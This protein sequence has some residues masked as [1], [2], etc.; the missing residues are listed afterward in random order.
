MANRDNNIITGLDIGSSSVRIAVGKI[1]DEKYSDKVLQILSLSQVASEGVSRGVITSIEDVVS[2]VSSC[3]ELAE[4]SIGMPIDSTWLGISGTQTIV[5]NSKGYAAVAKSDNEITSADV[6]R[7]MESSSSI[8]TPLN[9]EVL[10]TSP[11]SYNVDGQPGIKDPVGMTG[12]R[13]EVDTKIVLGQS[14]QIKNLSRAV[15][16]AGLEVNDFVL[17]QLANA[18]LLLTHRQ[19][20]LGVVFVNIGSQ[21]TSVTVYEEGDLL[22]IAILPIGSAHITN[23]LAVGLRASVDV[24]EKIKLEYGDC[25][26][27]GL[28]RKE[29]L[30][31]VDFGALEHEKFKLRDINTI[32]EA[33]V[34]EIFLMVDRE[35]KTI[36]RSGLLPAGV[37]LTGGGAKIKGIIEVAKKTL[38]LSAVIGSSSG[39]IGSSNEVNDPIFSTSIGLV[40][41]GADMSGLGISNSRLRGGVAR[42]IS[43]FFNLNN[44]KKTISKLIP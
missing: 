39:I 25:S 43:G 30:D 2:S 44:I 4:R 8:S 11:K 32:I 9:Y 21:T 12:I 7:A 15:Y 14:A 28:R 41:W 13:L 38:R 6:E 22:H 3:L 40:R 23:D 19:K 5:Q 18:N 24:V 20:D 29:E 26:T 31:I 37:V 34:D 27:E 35:L 16:R 42:N 36:Q 33:R 17:S 10:H 1:V